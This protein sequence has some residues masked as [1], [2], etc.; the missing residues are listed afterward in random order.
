MGL[1][2]GFYVTGIRMQAAECTTLVAYH[3]SPYGVSAFFNTAY[4][5]HIVLHPLMRDKRHVERLDGTFVQGEHH[6][7]V[8]PPISSI[9][10]HDTAP[11]Q[12]WLHPVLFYLAQPSL[13]GGVAHSE[14][15]SQLQYGLLAFPIVSP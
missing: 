2:Q 11:L 8:E 6:S 13:D 3:D 1:G 15:C 10:V 12:P 9:E 7:P 4:G 5:I 14:C